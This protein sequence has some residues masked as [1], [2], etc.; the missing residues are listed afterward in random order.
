MDA[1][2]IIQRHIDDA[3]G[4]KFE[5]GVEDCATWASA[6]IYDLTGDDLI[7]HWAGEANEFTCKRVGIHL[8]RVARQAGWEKI[9]PH[10][11][12]TGAVGLV[13]QPGGHVAVVANGEGW[14]IGRSDTGVVFISCHEVVWSCQ[15]LLSPQQPQLPPA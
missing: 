7:Q 1:N 13:R 9:P 14:Y 2:L 3:L 8:A 15:Q 10:H 12:R 4:V 6:L 11:A 5:L